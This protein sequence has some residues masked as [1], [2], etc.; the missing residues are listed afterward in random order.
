[1]FI[2]STTPLAVNMRHTTPQ[3]SFSSYTVRPPFS[4]HSSQI[5]LSFPTPVHKAAKSDSMTNLHWVS[6]VLKVSVNIPS[7]QTAL[8]L[9]SF[10]RIRIHRNGNIN[11]A[12]IFIMCHPHHN[13]VGMACKNPFW[14]RLEALV[15]IWSFTGLSVMGIQGRYWSSPNSLIDA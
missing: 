11:F 13:P 1:M 4:S 10:S 7:F 6:V 2:I 8:G 3:P 9:P 5:P 12:K 15:M 14:S